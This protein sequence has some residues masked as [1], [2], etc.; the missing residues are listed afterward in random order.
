MANLLD[1][2]YLDKDLLA[3]D[4]VGEKEVLSKETDIEDSE[5]D[6]IENSEESEEEDINKS[7]S[8]SE[9]LE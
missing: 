6:S 5:R 9:E 8:E 3:N 1:S 2:Q 7:E 4:P